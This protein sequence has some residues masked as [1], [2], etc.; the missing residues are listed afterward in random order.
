MQY[1]QID[2]STYPRREHFEH[3]LTMEDPFVY[4]TSQVDVTDWQVRRRQAGAPFFLSFQYAVVQAANRV[5]AFRQRIRG[6]GI[7]EYEFCDPSYT[8]ALPDGTYRYCLVHAN[9]PLAAYLEEGRVKQAAALRSAHLDE[10]GDVAGQLFISC[11]P[12]IDYSGLKM[13]FPDKRFSIPCFAWGRCRTEKRLALEGGAVVERE[14]ASLPVTVM[15]H[16]ALVDGVHIGQFFA[17]LREELAG[18][19]A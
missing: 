18:E 13:P 5:P 4:L 17:C 16:H 7:V 3:F 10:E 11:V 12:D 19:F 1:K 2:L 15:V 8:V 14:R 9:Q 6:E